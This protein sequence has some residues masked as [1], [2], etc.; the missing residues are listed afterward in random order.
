MSFTAWFTDN[1]ILLGF[2]SLCRSSYSFRKQR[3]SVISISMSTIL[4]ALK[5]EVMR[6]GYSSMQMHLISVE[7][8]ISYT[9]QEAILEHFCLLRYFNTNNSLSKWLLSSVRGYFTIKSCY[10]IC[11]FV[12]I[13]QSY[14]SSL[15]PCVF[16][17]IISSFTLEFK[18]KSI[19]KIL[20]SSLFLSIIELNSI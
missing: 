14:V 11:G 15:G 19:P 16:S 1:T 13:V 7:G 4:W 6:R 2:R 20:T 3:P 18:L 12:F 8:W 17:S 9:K 5:L 10:L